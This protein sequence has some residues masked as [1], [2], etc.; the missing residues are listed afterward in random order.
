M[1]RNALVNI[2]CEFWMS[3]NK[4][5]NVKDYNEAVRQIKLLFPKES[6]VI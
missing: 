2:I 5:P 1:N 6:E 3:K 4:R